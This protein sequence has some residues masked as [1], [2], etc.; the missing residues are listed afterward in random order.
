M[1]G[2]GATLQVIGHRGASS[3]TPENTLASFRR[4]LEIGVDAVELDVHLSSDGEPV[5]LHDPFLERTTDGRGLV[6]GKSLAELRAL[7][8]GAWF[9]E[10]FAGERI[11]TL[12][13]AL[14]L[15]EPIR[16]IVELKSGPIYYPSM[17]DRVVAAIRGA[18]HGRVT[19]SSFDHP[20]LLEVRSRAPDIPTAVLYVGRLVNP[21][22]M[23]EEAGARLLHLHWAYLT[24]ELVTAA[25]AAGLGVEVWTVDEPEHLAHVLRMRPDGVMTNHP[26]RLRA[27]LAQGELQAG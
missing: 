11:P 27:L 13:E 3:E 14:G 5:V 2:A 16:V 1:N 26:A 24:P 7:D 22:R 4:A 15:L 12:G 10:R 18:D 23:A 19:V 8:A 25:N 21:V 20:L 6:G 17:A 9:G